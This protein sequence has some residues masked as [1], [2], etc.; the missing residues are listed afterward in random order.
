MI[1]VEEARKRNL[2]KAFFAKKRERRSH[3][4]EG[5]GVLKTYDRD[6]CGNK[7]PAEG[8]QKMSDGGRNGADSTM[9]A[10]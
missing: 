10:K 7:C 5:G 3:P 2:G 1:C 4:T 8:L 9:K 6:P